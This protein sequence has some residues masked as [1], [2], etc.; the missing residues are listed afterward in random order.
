MM[1]V[2]DLFSGI[3]GFSLGLERAGMRTVAFCEIDPYARKVLA[4]HWPEVPI[5]DDVRTLTAEQLR[6]DGIAVDVI[7]GGFPCQPFSSASAGKRSGTDDDRYLWPEMLR[8]VADLRP[9]WVCAENVVG[10]DGMALEQVVSD[11]E[12]EGYEVAPILEIPACAIGHDHRRNRYW[13]LG[14]TDR[15]GEPVLPIDAKVAGLPRTRSIAYRGRETNGVSY[16]M[17]RLRCLGNAVVPQ[18]VEIIGS[19]IMQSVP[20]TAGTKP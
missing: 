13:F 4:K 8:L 7:C 14:Y 3:G 5:Y 2:L 16:R 18:V 17:D 20:S 12:A 11:L 6:A 15:Q 10:I 19:A 1:R 9:A